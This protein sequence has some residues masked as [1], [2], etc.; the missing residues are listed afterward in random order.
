MIASILSRAVA[1]AILSI[2][3]G[4]L[5]Q[6]IDDRDWRVIQEYSQPELMAYLESERV[7]S[8]LVAVLVVFLVGCGFTACVELLAWLLRQFAFRGTEPTT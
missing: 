6:E 8:H 3:A 4:Y 5:L 2:P 7:P 1:I